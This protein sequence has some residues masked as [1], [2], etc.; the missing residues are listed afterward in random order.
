MQQN[1]SR[2]HRWHTTFLMAK[3]R[4]F[5]FALTLRFHGAPAWSHLPCH[6]T[7]GFWKSEFHCN[8]SR[9]ATRRRMSDFFTLNR[10]R[11][12]LDSSKLFFV[13]GDSCQLF[14]PNL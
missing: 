8:M 13:D 6:A 4:E 5:L 1:I 9:L 2:H 14:K 3:E 10:M 7:T 11:S 12:R